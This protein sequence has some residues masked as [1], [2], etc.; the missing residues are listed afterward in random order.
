MKPEEKRVYMKEYNA[1]YQAK[2]K[3][4]LAKQ[5]KE[6]AKKNRTHLKEYRK[7]YYSQHKARLSAA[8]RVRYAKISPEERNKKA[9]A[10]RKKNRLRVYGYTVKRRAL[11]K[12]AAINLKGI[13]DFVTSVKSHAYATCYYCGVQTSTKGIHFDH[14][15]PLTKGGAHS[16]DN[17]CVSCASCNH[18]KGA[19]PLAIWLATR[20]GQQ[21][22]SL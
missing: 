21:L 9:L 11:K 6:W 22:L 12:A 14:I 1:A 3:E 19:K 13:L 10:W 7:A 20:D 15:V 5:A 4:R 2:H 16:A 17:L 18:S 8:G